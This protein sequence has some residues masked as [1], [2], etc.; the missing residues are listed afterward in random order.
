MNTFQ[1]I[2][3]IVSLIP[4]GKVMTYKQVAQKLN[5]PNPRVV[6]FA[7]RKNKDPK[8]IPCH[9]VVGASGN[10]TGYVFGGIKTKYEILKKEGVIFVD[11][12]H[13][14][15]QKSIYQTIQ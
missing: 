4:K 15:L 6:G 8:H 9:R 10:L 14:D 3:N 13:V 7:L 12:K 1:K 2:Y 5:I 11:N